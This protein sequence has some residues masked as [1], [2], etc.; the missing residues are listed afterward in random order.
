[1]TRD[2]AAEARGLPREPTAPWILRLV[3]VATVV[4]LA[5][6]AWQVMVLPERVPTHFGSGGEADGWSSKTGA[7]AFSALL[8]LATAYPLPLLSKLVLYA[9]E[10]I[11]SPNREWWT[12]TAPRLRRFERLQREDMWLIAVLVLALLSAMQVAIVLASQSP[13]GAIGPEF[14]FGPLVV[15]LVLVLAVMVRMFGSRYAEQDV[16]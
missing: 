12:A 5:I 8:P 3:A 2:V 6:L 10:W 14:L 7:L 4:W 1:M 11:N 16:D 9:P 15:F 13:G